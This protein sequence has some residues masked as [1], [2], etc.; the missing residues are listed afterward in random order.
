[1][2]SNG[3]TSNHRKWHL[4]K[5]SIKANLLCRRCMKFHENLRRHLKRACMK[6]SPEAEIRNEV[7][8]A[9]D[10]LHKMVQSLSVVPYDALKC[11]NSQ[12]ENPQDFFVDFLERCGCI[13]TDKPEQL[14]EDE[15]PRSLP[16][17][18]EAASSS[19]NMP[20]RRRLTVSGLHQKHDLQSP[21]LVS[22]KKYLK[23]KC[24]ETTIEPMIQNVSRFLYFVNPDEITVDFIKDLKV[25]KK[26]FRTLEMLKTKEETI[27]KHIGHLRTFTHFV[28]SDDYPNDIDDETKDAVNPFEETLKVMEKKLPK[29]RKR[30]LDPAPLSMADCCKVLTVAKPHVTNMFQRAQLNKEL[31]DKEK[32]LAC[33]YLQAILV[34]KHLRTPSAAQNLMV[35]EWIER[36]QLKLK[37]QV[38]TVIKTEK[39]IVILQD[40][41]EQYFRTYFEKI[42][43]TKHGNTVPQ[44]LVSSNGQRIMNC[45]QDMERFHEKYQLPIISWKMA[46]KVFKNW[47]EESLSQADGDLANAYVLYDQRPDNVNTSQLAAG[48]L[49]LTTQKGEN[50]AGT[51][52]STKPKRRRIREEEESSEGQTDGEEMEDTGSSISIRG[53]ESNE[54][55]TDEEETDEE[56]TDE[57]ETNRQ[58]GKAQKEFHYSRLLNKY[59]VGLHHEPPSL[60][61]CRRY[62]ERF[63]QYCRDKWRR[64]QYNLRVLDVAEHFKQIPNFEDLNSYVKTQ[65]WYLN[66]PGL[67]DVQRA[68]K[69][70]PRKEHKD[71]SDKLRALV[72]SQ[73]WKGLLITDDPYKDQTLYTTHGFKTGEIVCD[74]HGVLREGEEAERLQ[75]TVRD[76]ECYMYFFKSGEKSW[77][78]DAREAPCSC[79]PDMSSTF[80]RKINHS[81]KKDNLIPLLKYIVDDDTPSILFIAKSDL[82]PGTELFFNYGM[83]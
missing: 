1:M 14:S 36:K 11:E 3:K 47:A 73:D 34:Y 24:A 39:N 4:Q 71:H 59:P 54:G 27:R 6:T 19:A 40:E 60:P 76:N 64:K 46:I 35:K 5:K 68:W 21:I 80:G 63:A 23:E 70:R 81:C 50:P 74:F 25:T 83:K 12:F 26:Y 42:R 78:L 67:E 53:E 65:R 75:E 57:E 7:D 16:N 56:K 77:C 52:G 72:Q 49:I 2:E 62:T 45:S 28:L 38:V 48:M 37:G 10:N 66:V 51:S 69:P 8:T 82:K 61:T 17:V 30:S 13:V 31:G 58:T 9:K 15:D 32:T 29:G 44:F 33:Y 18:L 22:F 41:D 43:L 20:L 55:Q 79:H